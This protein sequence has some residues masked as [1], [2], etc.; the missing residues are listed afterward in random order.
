MQCEA[1]CMVSGLES[2]GRRCRKPAAKTQ[3]QMGERKVWL[4]AQHH[5]VLLRKGLEVIPKEEGEHEA[6]P[7][8]PRED[9]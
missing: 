2:Y 7:P 4:C 9:I 1:L 8:S 5:G 3:I 6:R